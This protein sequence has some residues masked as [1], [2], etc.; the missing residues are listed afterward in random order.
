MKTLL[1]KAD[2]R[3]FADHGWLKTNHTFSFAN[4]Y[5]PERVHFGALRVLNDDI[6]LGGQGFGTH[7]HDNMEIIS[8]PI[9]GALAHKDSMGHVQAIHADEIQVMSAGT[10]ITHSEYNHSE[11]DPA[12]FLQIWIFP[13]EKG[14]KPRYDQIQFDPNEFR[15]TLKTVVNP[16][17]EGGLFIQQDAWIS[18]CDLDEGLKL[19]YKL[20]KEGNGVYFFLIEGSM[21]IG[22][23][24]LEQRDGLGIW[25]SNNIGI[26]A[27]TKSRLLVLEVPMAW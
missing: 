27:K 7:P 10:G 16:D 12:N 4:Y 21:K 11:T 3:G 14:L 1:H 13:R 5:N 20:R 15:N 24:I 25:E 23:E 6:I 19:E 18:L 8:I 2:S 9:Y 22:N 17:H 26:Q